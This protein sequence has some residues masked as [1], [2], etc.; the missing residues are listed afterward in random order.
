MSTEGRRSPAAGGPSEDRRSTGRNSVGSVRVVSSS[1]LAFGDGKISLFAEGILDNS[2][3]LPKKLIEKETEKLPVTSFESNASEVMKKADSIVISNNGVKK[4]IA[5]NELNDTVL[6]GRINEVNNTN[7]EREKVRSYSSGELGNCDEMLEVMPQRINPANNLNAWNRNKNIKVA[8]LDY[9]DCIAEDG[10]TVKLHKEKVCE[11]AMK[12]NK[13]LVVKIFGEDVQFSSISY[14]LRRQW[15]VFGKFHLTILGKGWVLCSFFENEHL[16][17]VL[18]NGPWFVNGNIIGIEKWNQKFDP[19]S[20]DGLSAPVW[21]RL[22]NLPL[23]CWDEV[24][25]CR[26][27]SM[28]GKPYLIDGNMFQWSRRE[29]GRI[30]V[31]IKLIDKLPIGVWVEGEEVKFYQKIENERLSN[32]CFDCGKIGHDKKE[33]S[34]SSLLNKDNSDQMKMDLSKDNNEKSTVEGNQPNDDNLHNSESYGPWLMVNYGKKNANKIW[35]RRPSALMNKNSK[36]SQQKQYVAVKKLVNIEP[37]LTGLSPAKKTAEIAMEKVSAELIAETYSLIPVNNSFNILKELEDGEINETITNVNPVEN[38]SYTDVTDSTLTANKGEMKMTKSIGITSNSIGTKGIEESS[39]SSKKKKNKQLKDLGPINASSRSRRIEMEE[40]GGIII[41]WNT[42]YVN[43]SVEESST[44]MLK[45]EINLFNNLKWKVVT[46]YGSTEV[47]KRRDLWNMLDKFSNHEYPMLK[48]DL[49]EEIM[50]LQNKEAS[51]GHLTDQDY[52]ILKAKVLEL[53]S[54]L[55]RLNT[56]WKQRAKVNWLK[57][58]DGNSSFFHN[59]ASA[60]RNVNKIIKIKD[61]DG[62]TIEDQDHMEEVFMRFFQKKREI[63]KSNL[64]GWP[65][66]T[67]CLNEQDR[68]ILEADLSMAEVLDVLKQLEENTSPES[69]K[70]VLEYF[71]FPPHFSKLVMECVVDPMFSIIINGN[72]S[73]WIQARSGFRQ[74]C[75]LSPILFILCSQL[76]SNAFYHSTCGIKLCPEGPRISH[77]LYAD[78]VIMLSKANKKEV[79]GVKRILHK[80]CEWTGQKINYSKS[81]IM[82]GKHVERKR[83]RSLSRIMGFKYVKEFLYLGVKMA[84]RRLKKEDFQSIIDEAFKKLNQ[85]GNKYLSLPGKI[86][87]VKS[88]LL[89]LPIY[90]STHSLV[91]KK[92]LAE[93]DKICRNFI[94]DKKNGAKGMHYVNWNEMCKP[95]EYGGRGIHSN[96][97]KAPDLHARLAWRFVQEEKSLFHSVMDAKYGN[98][99]MK[100]NHNGNNSTAFKILNEGFNSLYPIVKWDIANGKSVDAFKDIW[101]LD[102]SINNWPTFVIPVEDGQFKVE[103]FI[104]EG[105]WDVNNLRKVFG[106]EL[107]EIIRK[108]QIFKDKTADSLVLINQNSGMTI[109]GLIRKVQNSGL[110]ADMVWKWIKKAKLNSR[111]EN[112]WWRLKRNVIP[113]MHF[114]CYRRIAVNAQC[115]RGCE[116]NEDMEHIVCGCLKIKETIQ[117]L[118]R[119]GFGFPLF[120]S[121]EQCLIW[122]ENNVSSKRM[123]VNIYCTLVFL[124][125][126]S[127]NKIIH[128]GIEDNSSF[129]ASEAIVQASI[130]NKFSSS[131]LGFWDVNQSLRL[132]NNWHPPP[133]NWIKANVD[134]SLTSS[135]KAGIAAVFRDNKGRFLYAYGK[136][137]THWDIGQLELLAINSI[138]E[139]INEWMFKYNG[140]L[141]EVDNSNIISFFKKVLNKGM[142][143]DEGVGEE[144]LIGGR[145]SVVVDGEVFVMGGGDGW[146]EV[147]DDEFGCEGEGMRRRDGMGGFGLGERRGVWLVWCYREGLDG[148]GDSGDLDLRVRGSWVFLI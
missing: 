18:N 20:L 52:W 3:R 41:L 141:I 73:N 128:G 136:S 79:L 37:E 116:S 57:E 38:V 135:Y 33:C 61:E 46:I 6:E 4:S 94:W 118:N 130:T 142:L 140:I 12:L 131:N 99:L 71:K 76:L 48:E 22:P 55:A 146:G 125:W 148:V 126:K 28:V 34:K 21:I 145:D 95:I 36:I 56:W 24:N 147:C 77:L 17:A 2:G 44:Q 133:P 8:D 26:I 15:D 102:K 67:N 83:K 68:S 54:T 58:G 80:F 93:L 51:N 105:N 25:I 114:L 27:D 100:E 129:I 97:T 11:N 1:P 65:D 64:V 111:V 144:V 120:I 50:E 115:P 110:E 29:F 53:N 16:E 122:L 113:S 86:I 47:R 88:V 134:A 32:L 39:Q 60:R 84:L 112:F 59:Y 121:S 31:R 5:I 104:S 106:K 139:E 69:L 23:F 10:R 87:L 30:C 90:H 13:S 91:P 7:S 96:L 101:I 138:K 85:W 98:K 137:F 127:R 9:G 45:G 82:F 124:S 63:K 109:P 89:A 14:E 70:G 143:K 75:P 43:F 123:M 132:S 40:K 117:H 19:N 81:V 66:P 103:A 72:C 74:G 49:M 107:V 35:N 42:N 92:F 108:I 62:N 119:W 78:D